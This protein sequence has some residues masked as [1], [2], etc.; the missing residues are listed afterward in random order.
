MTE[1]G[2]LRAL[3]RATATL[4]RTVVFG[5]FPRRVPV[6]AI[7][8][9]TDRIATAYDAV[10]AL[11]E[12]HQERRQQQQQDGQNGKAAA[13]AGVAKG[14]GAAAAAGGGG[15]AATR[16]LL[17][18][19]LHL[20][21]TAALH[22]APNLLRSAALGTAVFELYEEVRGQLDDQLDA[23]PLPVSSSSEQPLLLPVICT[24]AGGA[25]GA[26]HGTL[27]VGWEY[28]RVALA[29]LRASMSSSPRSPQVAAAAVEHV[30]GGTAAAHALAHA[31]LFGAFEVVKEAL[32]AL[33][34]A[35]HE[36]PLGVALV[37]LAG[38]TAGVCEEAASHFTASWEMEG[39]SSLRKALKRHGPPNFRSIGR[40]ATLPSAIGF[41]AFEYG[42]IEG[43]FGDDD[44]E[45]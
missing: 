35:R 1:A 45:D 15:G 34:G 4:Y 19:K 23:S 20:F 8:P 16:S 37:G 41:L 3:I 2:A 39:V 27:Y 38:A 29:R 21:G 30:V 40:T 28:G 11:R 17:G 18:A 5:S 25:A 31:T 12:A 33:T 13:A 22:A 26:C 42:R 7:G 9:L 44:D 36:E 43:R 10:T 32:F 14:G 24:A 6:K